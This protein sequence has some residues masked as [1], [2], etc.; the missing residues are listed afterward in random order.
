MDRITVLL[1]VFLIFEI[2]ILF[3]ATQVRMQEFPKCSSCINGI[4]TYELDK[5][6]GYSRQ[7]NSSCLP[8]VQSF[9]LQIKDW[10]NIIS[11]KTNMQQKFKNGQIK[12]NFRREIGML[13]LVDGQLL[14][15]F[16]FRKIIKQEVNLTDK[17]NYCCSAKENEFCDGDD[18]YR[19]SF[20]D[21]FQNKTTCYCSFINFSFE[22]NFKQLQFFNAEYNVTIEEKQIA[23]NHINVSL[24][25]ANITSS[26]S[27]WYQ[28]CDLQT[29][30]HGHGRSFKC[31]ETKNFLRPH[32][33]HL[34]LSVFFENEFIEEKVPV[35]SVDFCSTIPC[36]LCYSYWLN[37]ECSNFARLI[38]LLGIIATIYCVICM[39]WGLSKF[40]FKKI[41]SSFTR[42][43]QAYVLL[44][45]HEDNRQENARIRGINDYIN[46]GILLSILLIFVIIPS[47]ACDQVYAS[48]GVCS[49][50]H[51]QH[52]Y[53]VRIISGKEICFTLTEV[54]ETIKLNIQNSVFEARSEL[55]YYTSE[56]IPTSSSEFH[57]YWTSS[58]TDSYN[59]ANAPVKTNYNYLSWSNSKDLILSG[60]NRVAS[61][62]GNGC[63][64]AADACLYWQTSLD[65]KGTIWQVNKIIDWLPKNEIVIEYRTVKKNILL[66][67]DVPTHAKVSDISLELISFAPKIETTA[68]PKF[69]LSSMDSRNKRIAN[70]VSEKENPIAGLIGQVQ[71]V[72]GSGFSEANC[73]FDR[74]SV[75]LTPSTWFMSATWENP[76]ITRKTKPVPT[77]IADFNIVPHEDTLGAHRISRDEINLRIEIDSPFFLQVTTNSCNV[78][79]INMTGCYSCQSG[80]HLYI[81]A[82][83][84]AQVSLKSD[85]SSLN[86]FVYV[87]NGETEVRFSSENKMISSIVYWTCGDSKGEF[88][89][90]GMLRYVPLDLHGTKYDEVRKAIMKQHGVNP[91]ESNFSFDYTIFGTALKW[92]LIILGIILLFLFFIK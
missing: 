51:C 60:C 47:E 65:S 46:K 22:P 58:C 83:S 34:K 25:Q 75:R 17:N 41:F 1:I 48:T 28:L 33:N 12:N 81:N 4:G 31:L 53:D 3:L 55:M 14:Q 86:Q 70:I 21:R 24:G 87:L 43:K 38:A 89:I 52:S 88:K 8:Q 54:N 39:V 59:C 77:P 63:F 50:T 49:T 45:Q 72:N 78:S 27:F 84:S 7:L 71:C 36:Y 64:S 2:N 40:L 61:G 13:Y 82:T 35:A 90:Q 73:M 68:L 11:L 5:S 20:P 57:C 91:I 56:L 18:V 15:G 29:C 9:D 69:F 66:H 10:G 44:R 74:K 67:T 19:H 80:A 30:V 62:W 79:F 37:L 23:I 32:E 42:V 85:I 16:H 76:D 92:I 6:T 26:G